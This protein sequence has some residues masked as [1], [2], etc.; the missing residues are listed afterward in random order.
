MS[1][2]YTFYSVNS[3]DNRVCNS[4]LLF[5]TVEELCNY[6]DTFLKSRIG[7]SYTAP[8]HKEIDELLYKLFEDDVIYYEN[9]NITW[10]VRGLM[11][12]N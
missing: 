3:D 1:Y 11:L 6:L 9:N 5:R 4:G 2:Y 10:G 7:D 8:D 12:V